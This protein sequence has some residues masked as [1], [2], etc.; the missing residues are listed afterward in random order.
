VIGGGLPVGAYAAPKKLM[1]LVSPSGPM[2]QA[3]TLSGNPVAM[4]A[5]IATLEILKE[6]GTYETLEERSAHLEKGLLVAAEQAGVPIAINRAGSM[7]T[8]F[9]VRSKGQKVTNFN[10]AT[11]SDT[12]AFATFFNAMLENGVYLPPSQYEAWF[13]GLAHSEEAIDKT[14]EAAKVAFAVVAKK[15]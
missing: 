8:P 3:G 9:F 14:I 6:P 5:G 4:N 1:E 12:Q 2:Y 10:E 11:S 7:L 15:N 13:V